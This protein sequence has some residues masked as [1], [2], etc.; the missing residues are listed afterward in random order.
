MSF[1]IFGNSLSFKIGKLFGG[2]LNK[3]L[4][5]NKVFLSTEGKRLETINVQTVKYGKEIPIVYGN[6][7]LAGNIIWDSGLK[8][9]KN[10]ISKSH[11][12]P[13]QSSEY[14]YTKYE[15]KISLAIALC[16]GEIEG[17]SRIWINN[18]IINTQIIILWT[19]HLKNQVN[20]KM[21]LLGYHLKEI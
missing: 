16:E 13:N 3:K 14:S 15:Y 7:K 19:I 9:L 2:I 4:F 1:E 8:E 11:N 10:V 6:V 12:T 21:T 18:I 20:I 17:V 5:K